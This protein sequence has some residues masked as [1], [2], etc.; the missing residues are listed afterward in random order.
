[1]VAE[2]QR[3]HE[4]LGG[5]PFRRRTRRAARRRLST[6]GHETDI[7]GPI[8]QDVVVSTRVTL[9]TVADEVG[10]S[11]ATVSNAYNRPDQLSPALRD[12]IFL[13]AARLGY[14]GPDAA[15]RMLRTGRMRSIGL[16]FTEDLRYVFNDPDTMLFMQGV[17]ETSALAGS[18]LMLLPVPPG[19]DIADTAVRSVATDGHLV[20]SVD[21]RHPAVHALVAAGRPMVT[22]DEPDLGDR[23]S[24]VGIDDRRGAQLACAHLIELG[25]RRL[26]VLLGRLS[27]GAEAAGPVDAEQE[28]TITLRIARQRVDGYRDAFR[29]AGLDPGELVLWAA[30]GNDPDSARSA[31]GPFLTAHPDI[32]GLLCFSDQLAIGASQAAQRLGKRVP[33]DLSIVGFD[34]V[35]RAATW[36]PPLTTIRQPLVDKGRAAADLLLELIAGR[37]PRRIE[38]P[39]ELVV[40]ASSAPPPASDDD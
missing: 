27:S 31:T 32:S 14:G 8:G 34:D 7:G 10:V 3:H 16:L 17:A 6:F 19:M 39:I 4:A 28:S 40:R 35:P 13:A 22:I 1:M 37:P 38:L 30:G 9:Q 33:D 20:F 29:A 36:D 25:H 21:D 5:Q 2:R 24:F 12:R 15:A 23:T 18:G 11:R 26:G